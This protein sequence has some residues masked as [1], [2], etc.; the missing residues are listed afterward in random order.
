MTSPDGQRPVFRVLEP[1]PYA[2]VQDA[3]R[4]GWQQFGVPPS[5]ALD[6]YSFRLANWL[7][8]N[9]E[10]AAVLELTFLG[11]RLEVLSS[12]DVALTGAD[13]PFLVN[14]RPM[15]AWR[16][17]R[18]EAGDVIRLRQ[19]R[20]GLRAYLA[21]GGGVAAPPVMGSRSTYP[22]AALGGLAGRPLRQGDLVPAYP[23][24]SLAHPRSTPEEFV[25][26]P[27]R[28]I[29][30][31]AVPGPQDDHFS[32]GLDTFFGAAYKVSS[33]VDRM[34]YRLEGPA[35][36]LAPG[37]PQSIISE[38]TLPGGVQIPPDGQPIVLLVEQTTSGYNKIATVVTADLP[39]LA[40]ARPGD[41]VR[42]SRLSLEQ[43]WEKLAAFRSRLAR[44]K[45][46]ITGQTAAT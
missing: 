43:G 23:A 15:P 40:Q 18:V 2:T 34:G 22:A 45:A 12:A 3:G 28:E 17:V 31:G 46:A 10:D 5:G 42:F 16:T 35:V 36:A 44:A 19:V 27:S 4:V 33:K 32:A 1:G 24:A 41:T 30:L 29:T 11:P 25:P 8:G 7:V 39:P 37:A 21:V 6:Q 20:S 14:D 26:V 38:P 9:A 13:M